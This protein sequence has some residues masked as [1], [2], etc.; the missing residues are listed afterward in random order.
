M[1]KSNNNKKKWLGTSGK[2]L[3]EEHVVQILVRYA[4]PHPD[5]TMIDRMKNI[6]SKQA[7]SM[8]RKLNHLL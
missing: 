7:L 6:G 1:I 5:L 8:K 2:Y 3:S 4:M